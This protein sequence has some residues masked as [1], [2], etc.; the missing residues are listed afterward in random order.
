MTA[1]TC[2]IKHRDNFKC[3]SMC[4]FCPHVWNWHN[5]FKRRRNS[6]LS[7]WNNFEI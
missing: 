7:L 6:A 2:K 3:I 1:V 5:Y 4:C